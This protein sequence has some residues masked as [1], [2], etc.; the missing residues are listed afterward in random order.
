MLDFTVNF[1]NNQW[2]HAELEEGAVSELELVVEDGGW[3][4][5]CDSA[6]SGVTPGGGGGGGADLAAAPPSPL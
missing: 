1:L 2:T 4:L 5:E 6:L 3:F